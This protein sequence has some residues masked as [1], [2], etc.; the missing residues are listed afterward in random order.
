MSGQ[1]KTIIN[2]AVVL[3]DSFLSNTETLPTGIRYVDNVDYQ[4]FVDTSNATGTF[5]FQ[6]TL[7]EPDSELYRALVAAGFDPW[8]T[9]PDISIPAVA[10]ADAVTLVEIN[11]TGGF[12]SRI[13]YTT[14]FIESV[15]IA[16][17]ADSSGS[18]NS[19]Y[20]LINGADGTNWYVWYN[21][22]SAGVDPAIADRTGI[23]VTAA[24]GASAN[25]LASATKTALAA[26]TSI[27]TIGGATN[28]VTFVQ[29]QAGSGS[30]TDGAAPTGFSITYT[31]P[32]GSLTVLVSG[33]GI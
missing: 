25:T 10:G 9:N 27:T 2:A 23:E 3:E 26:C 17:V 14:T 22:N 21:I 5:D 6:I 31:A 4:I 7:V 13:K 15:D 30:V 1:V 12:W 8:V 33:K 29:D 16:T 20:F 32:N 24:T 18:L 19:K 28:H 11:Q